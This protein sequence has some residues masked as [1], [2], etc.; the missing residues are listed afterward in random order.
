[1]LGSIR[2]LLGMGMGIA[3][4]G[5]LGPI[6][7]SS[8]KAN[9][10]AR[11]VAGCVIGA[12]VGN[13]VALAVRFREIL[14]RDHELRA[15]VR[16]VRR[17]AGL[18]ES[19]RTRI[20]NARLTVEGEVEDAATRCRTEHVFASVPGLESVNNQLRLAP[21]AAQAA[22]SSNDI[23]QRIELGLRRLASGEGKRIR[24]LLQDENHVVLEGTVHSV[25]EASQAEEIAWNIPG[26]A[27]VDN[28][29]EIAA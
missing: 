23:R 26:V 12:A 24:V 8:W 4:G 5:P 18:P 22:P 11:T 27:E 13:A 14:L 2:H 29:L 16:A 21:R 3:I 10:P 15:A 17:E 7:F 1:M 25:F 28:R 9:V 6:L 19:I 20:W